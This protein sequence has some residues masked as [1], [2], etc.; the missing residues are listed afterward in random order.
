MV[1]HKNVSYRVLS[2][3]WGQISLL[4]PKLESLSLDYFNSL[5][6]NQTE[7][8]PEAEKLLADVEKVLEPYSKKQ[9]WLIALEMQRKITA[10]LENGAVMEDQNKDLQQKENSLDYELMQTQRDLGERVRA[11]NHELEIVEREREEQRQ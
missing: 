9:L 6:E 1:L 2:Q 4:P 10:L 5:L 11:L 3:K 7:S 8:P